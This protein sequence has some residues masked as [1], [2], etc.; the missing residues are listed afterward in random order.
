MRELLALAMIVAIPFG[1]WAGWTF[2]TLQGEEIPLERFYEGKWC[3]DFVV[4]PECTACAVSIGWLRNWQA[5]Q[6]RSRVEVALVVPWDTPELRASLE[7][8]PFPVVVDSQFILA[9]WFKVK[10]AP[11]VVLFAEAT[12]EEKLEWPFQEAELRAKLSEL[13]EFVIPRPQDLLGQGLPE[14]SGA[15]LTGSPVA[16]EDLPRPVFLFFF[17]TTCPACR[18]SLEMLDAVVERVP[19]ALLVLT[20]GHEFTS[21][22]REELAALAEKYGT[23]LH[24]VILGEKE[25][26]TME[27][28]RVRWTPTFFLVDA[29][30]KLAA[31]WEGSSENLILELEE[32]LGE[33]KG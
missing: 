30:G 16:S 4:A 23:R 5:E 22:D 10:V 24:I 19:V 29:T 17:S 18:A 12:F 2:P 20:K 7:D 8:V 14:F 11:T 31:V 13:A 33:R 9:S 25:R 21:E 6:T 32:L 26:E 15:D 28:F 3:L 27:S 1:V